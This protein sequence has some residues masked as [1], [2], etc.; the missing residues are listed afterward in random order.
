MKLQKLVTGLALT[1][2]LVGFSALTN[3]DVVDFEEFKPGTVITDQY[4]GLTFS[5][6][7]T[8]DGKT[9]SDLMIFDTAN[10]TGGDDDL[11]SP[12]YGEGNTDTKLGNVLIISED[13]DARDPDDHAGG[14]LLQI[15]F[16]D[17]VGIGQFGLLDVESGKTY[18]ELLD[19][20]G[21]VLETEFARDLGDNS[22]QTLFEKGVK[23]VST[24]NVFFATSGALSGFRYEALGPVAVSAPSG[25]ALML[26]GVGAMLMRRRANKA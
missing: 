16:E 10:P 21:E 14:G 4:K 26:V 6:T 1:A 9:L 24:V 8:I 13:N 25:L 5:T 22:F 18:V 17:L 23:G 19:S 7:Q 12:G 20:E 3:A 11:A 15:K 2:S